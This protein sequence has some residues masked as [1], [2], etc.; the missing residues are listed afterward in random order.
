MIKLT[1]RQKQILYGAILGDGYLQTTGK[2]NARLRLEHG[3]K[4][5]NYLLWKVKELSALF[6]GKPKYLERIHPKTRK[7]YC[8]WR[9]QSQSTPYLGKLRK[10]FYP[11][12][13]KKIPQDL[14]KYL[15][16]QMFAVWYMDDGY[17]CKRD[18]SSYL[19]VGK[20]S[21]K[22]ARTVSKNLKN[23][24]GIK[25]TILDK[26]NKGLAIYFSPIT[27]RQLKKILAPYIIPEFNYKFLLDPVTTEG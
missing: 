12:A 19:Y 23:S 4:Q 16:P 26:K 21:K 15:S 7:K 10:V 14:E 24:L 25:N 18:N 6:Q 8:Y 17:Y 22:E 20:I 9:H 27:T 1:K 13:R 5:K 11:D 2:K 3:Y